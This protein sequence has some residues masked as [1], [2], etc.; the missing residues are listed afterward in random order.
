MGNQYA[1]FMPL[2]TELGAPKMHFA[3]NMSRLA[4]LR[5]FRAPAF[6]QCQIT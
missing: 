4:A 1:A 5:C 2:R 6:Q 3:T